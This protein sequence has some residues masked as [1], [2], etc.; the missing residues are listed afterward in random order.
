VIREQLQRQDGEQ[1]VDLRVGVGDDDHFVA[2]GSQAGVPFRDDDCPRAARYSV[3]RESVETCQDLVVT[4]LR[5]ALMGTILDL[6]HLSK[7]QLLRDNSVQPPFRQHGL[8]RPSK[9]IEKIARYHGISNT[10]TGGRQR[11]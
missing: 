4:N 7:P 9:P 11:M 5:M 6:F 3:K 10:R 2:V 1:G 8:N